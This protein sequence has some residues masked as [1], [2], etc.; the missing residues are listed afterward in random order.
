MRLGGYVIEGI[1]CQ[2]TDEYLVATVTEH[3]DFC[4][5]DPVEWQ[6]LKWAPADI[7]ITKNLLSEAVLA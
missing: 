1:E 3:M 5:V 6:Q 7:P 4:W 2:Q